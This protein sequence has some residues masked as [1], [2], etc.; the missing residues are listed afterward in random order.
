MSKLRDWIAGSFDLV[1]V[2]KRLVSEV[3]QLQDDVAELRKMLAD[4][5]QQ[6]SATAKK[7]PKAEL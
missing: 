1:E 3:D 7:A 2:V 4:Q 6:P 5:R